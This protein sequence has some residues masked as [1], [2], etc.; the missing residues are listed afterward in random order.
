M[1]HEDL[2]FVVSAFVLG[3]ATSA[4][5]ECVIAAGVHFFPAQN[6]S[7]TYHVEMKKGGWSTQYRAGGQAAFTS[8]SILQGPKE[9]TLKQTGQLRCHYGPKPGYKGADKYAIKVCGRG[10]AG[11]G[12]TSIHYESTVD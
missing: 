2:V 5:A 12:C 11:A 8:A 10:L 4:R 9:G 7:V 6:D 3:C 1:S